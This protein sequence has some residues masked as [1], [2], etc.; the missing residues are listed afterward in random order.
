MKKEILTKEKIM[1][2]IK[3]NCRRENT[4][5]VTVTAF[6]LLISI[7]LLFMAVDSISFADNGTILHCIILAII[8]VVCLVIGISGILSSLKKSRMIKNNEFYIASDKLIDTS[9]KIS[10]M[11]ANV[12][13]VIFSLLSPNYLLRFSSYGS[14]II[15]KKNYEWSEMF[16]LD[17]KGVYN[18]SVVGD[19][20]HLIILKDKKQQILLAYNKK[21]FELEE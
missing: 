10:L 3:E 8:S 7:L 12:Y 4:A 19:E 2:D 11:G 1:Q 20:F 18:F 13:F 16:C 9:E 21:L 15:P 5:A 17:H 14:Y 6:F